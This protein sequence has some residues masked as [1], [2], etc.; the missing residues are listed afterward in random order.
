MS[1]TDRSFQNPEDASLVVA[2]FVWANGSPSALAEPSGWRWRESN[3]R[4]IINHNKS[5]C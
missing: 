1:H 5:K 4:G 2:P 3:D